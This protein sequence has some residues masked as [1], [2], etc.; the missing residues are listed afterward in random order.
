GLA[1][2]AL[3]PAELERRLPDAGHSLVMRRLHRLLESELVTYEHRPGQPPHA[4]SAPV[5]HE[6][7]Y[8]LTDAGRALLE[9][10]AEA[11]RWEQTWCSQ[12][13][14]HGPVGALAIKLTAD[15]HMREIT[16]L[17]ADGPL[18][19][20]DLD[21]RTPGLG[22]SAL[23]R[24]LR[25]LVLAGLLER[26]ERG[27]AALCELTDGAR[28]LALVAMLA[29][30]WEWQW[31]RPEHPAPGRDLDKLLHMLAPVAHTPEPMAGICQLH[32]DVRG[33]DDPDI[34]LAAR[35]GN[36]LA[37]AGAPAAP[38]EAVGH[39]T[40]EAWCDALLLRE[41]P[42]TISGNEALLAAVIAALSA[43]LL[44]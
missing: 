30:R 39:A 41:G 36:V 26:R 24:R 38:P 1:D 9:V 29:G 12:A 6:A 28:H 42:I 19:T 43:A 27:R 25:D 18:C 35:E 32:L 10:T 34:Y 31:S 15:E 44:A 14:R 3:R 2:G 40:P 17:L 22:R 23:R 7:H 5:P 37:L 11:G 33:A 4:R 8:D 20:T 16:L 21:G 13:E